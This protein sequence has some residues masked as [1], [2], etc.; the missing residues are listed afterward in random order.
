MAGVLY[1]VATPIGNL[2]DITLRALRI[3]KE[4]DW[5]ACEDTRHT[6]K[7]L[8]RYEVSKPL[9]S[10]FEHNKRIKG[11]WL[12]RELEEGKSVALVSDAGT[13]SLSDPGY[14]LVVS[15]V[16]RGIRVIPIPGPS[17][18][19]TALSAAGLPTDRFLFVGF[20]PQKKGRRLRFLQSLQEE[21]GTLVFYE[22]PFRIRRTLREM[23]EVF[24]DRRAVLAHELTKVHEAFIRGRLSE[25]PDRVGVI[26]KGEWTILLEG[27]TSIR[28]RK[29]PSPFPQIGEGYGCRSPCRDASSAGH[30]RRV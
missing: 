23:G 9:T 28:G 1:I 24:G 12:I 10:Y 4:V 18:V 20:L 8:T 6:R 17:A 7:L 16:E 3:L 13:P 21:P 19:A 29:T 22:S 5:I 14:P 30:H 15:A 25:L 11:D 2:E 26:E 27:K